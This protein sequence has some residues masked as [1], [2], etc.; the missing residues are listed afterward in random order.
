MIGNRTGQPTGEIIVCRMEGQKRHDRPV[1]IFDV[2]GLGFIPA[3]GIGIFAFRV[4]LG[5]SLG[6]EI[7]TNLVDGG[8][9]CPDTARENLATFLLLNDPML[10]RSLHSS[11]K[12]G[13]SGRQKSPIRWRR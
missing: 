3:S 9:R 6:F 13:I 10:A 5:G 1:E 12:S 7:D 11:C 8:S 4:S 2:F